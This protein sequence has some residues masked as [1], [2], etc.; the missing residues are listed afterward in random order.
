MANVMGT[1]GDD[2]IDDADG[3]TDN[4]DNIAALA[5][6]DV[7][8]G[9]GGSDTIDG[10]EGN[11]TLVG[12]DGGDALFGGAGEDMA[13][14]ANSA[15]S[16]TVDLG[17][18]SGLAGEALG[19]LLFGIEDITGSTFAD[20][21]YGDGFANIL[22]ALDGAD[23][24]YGG[25][26]NDGIFGGNGADVLYGGD[27][28]DAIRGGA[29]NDI[30][31]G[32]AGNDA[33]AGDAGADSFVGGAGIDLADYRES[34][35]G[36][37]VSLALGIGTGG[38]ATGDTLTE[39]ENLVGTD[40]A[41]SL[42]GD[43]GAN[44]LAG[45]GGADL[46]DGLGGADLMQGFNGNDIYGI[47][48]SGDVA[49]ETAPGS[50]GVDEVRSSISF[51]LA[52]AGHAKGDIENLTLIGNGNID[53][54]GNALANVL[55]GNAGANTLD[56]AGG[57]DLMRGLAGN[58]RYV[59]DNAGDVVDETVPGSNGVDEV[60]SAIGFSLADGVHAT[61]DIE[62]L[63]LTGTANIN[64][65]GNALANTI[66]GNVGANVLAGGSGNDIVAGGLGNDILTGGAGA[67]QFLFDTKLS[68]KAN[69]DTIADFSAADDTILLDDA[70]FTKLALGKLKG[71]VFYEGTKAHDAND[72]L[73]YNEKTG[74]LIYDVNGDHKGGAMLV[75]TL[76]QH[77]DLTKADF[78]VV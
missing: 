5:G 66:V 65:T 32:E 25:G 55:T 63:T 72:R 56:G 27:G 37:T 2:I 42:F 49:D 11:D 58:D 69:V 3:V 75:A 7:V 19:D 20:T 12:G 71:A 52:D 73:V 30:L 57:A 77:L 10:A 35:A 21:I 31:I 51:S 39:I 38:D 34:A 43:G 78:F 70:V 76:S 29:G 36:V 48:D 16:I 4:A 18:G 74:A 46:L 14:Y 15:S 61:G 64:G 23:Y 40:F 22:V 53:G 8:F 33:F 1:S 67:D 54:A 44:F 26:G 62:N 6:N 28:D 60:L 24:V 45:L 59:V 9:F 41:D 68:K 50:D 17:A 47:D 13:S